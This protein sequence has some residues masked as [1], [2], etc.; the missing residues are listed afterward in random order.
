MAYRLMQWLERQMGLNVHGGCCFLWCPA[1]WGLESRKVSINL[2]RNSWLRMYFGKTITRKPSLWLMKKMEGDWVVWSLSSRSLT[3]K[4]FVFMG[5][6]AGVQLWGAEARQLQNT[7][8]YQW[9]KLATGTVYKKICSIFHCFLSLKSLDWEKDF[10]FK[11]DSLAGTELWEGS[12]LTFRK[13]L[14]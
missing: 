5:K 14:V 9:W 4:D 11:E 3:P 2:G 10:F 6:G 1:F 12:H 8:F 7:S 13:V